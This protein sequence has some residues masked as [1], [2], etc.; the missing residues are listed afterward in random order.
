MTTLTRIRTKVRRLTSSP[1]INQLSET[2]LDNAINDF[3]TL[4]FPGSIR[5][6][7]LEETY[8]FYTSTN[9]DVYE[10][11]RDSYSSISKPVFISGVQSD[12]YEDR[13][14]FFSRYPITSYSQ[15]LTTGDGTSGPFTGTLTNLPVLRQGPPGGNNA[16]SR[17]LISAVDS[18]GATVAATD[19]SVSGDVG[20]LTGD[21]VSAGTVN[22]VTGAVSITFTSTIPSGNTITSQTVPYVA[23]KPIAALFYNDRITLRPVPNKAYKVQFNAYVLPTQLLNDNDSPEVKQWWEYIAYGAARKIFLDRQDM[24]GLASIQQEFDR[25][26]RICL[27]RTIVQNS[28]KRISTIYSDGAGYGFANYLGNNFGA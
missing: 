18:T 22:Y 12:F 21:G 25:Q 26:E 19:T 20:T 11:P 3:Y 6:L 23:G 1:S 15:D 7:N 28:Q 4:E 14:L 10:F 27:R 9:V 13:Q 16:D 2:D 24:E 5:T 8:T 17:V